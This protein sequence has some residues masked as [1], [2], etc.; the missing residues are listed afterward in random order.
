MT[1]FIHA[2]RCEARLEVVLRELSVEGIS[3]GEC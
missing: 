2:T 3:K 1:R